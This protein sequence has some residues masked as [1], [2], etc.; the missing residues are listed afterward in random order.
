MNHQIGRTLARLLGLFTLGLV[1][2]PS[3]HGCAACGCSLASDWES[4]G[5]SVEPGFKLDVTYAYLE[6]EQLRSG[7]HNISP[8]DVPEGQELEKSTRNNITTLGL[9]YIFN[10]DWGVSLDVPWVAREHS[11]LGESHDELQTS[12]TSNIGDLRLMGRFQGFTSEHR[13]GLTLGIKLA[14]GSFTDTFSSGEPLDR[15]LQPGTGTTDLL[16]GVYYFGTFAKN[17]GYFA[18]AALQTPLDSRADY[19]PGTAENLNVGLRYTGIGGV[20]PQFQVNG[21]IAG[22]DSGAEADALD[23]GGSLIFI[24]PGVTFEVTHQLA[25]YV[26]VQVPVYQNLNGY[27][28]APNWGITA[29]VRYVF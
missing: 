14:T 24:S 25:T 19:K 26:F 21:R 27:Q 6:Q 1:H 4:Q 9:D 15:G 3:A 20:I 5:Y 16:A 18:Q 28:L 22:R 17:W 11:T 7:T 13:F 10:S 29:G 12:S 2:A 8:S 23:S